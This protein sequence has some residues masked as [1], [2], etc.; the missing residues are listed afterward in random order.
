MGY[1]RLQ[2][3]RNL[4]ETQTKKSGRKE[5]KKKKGV[6]AG[7]F[8]VDKQKQQQLPDYPE[9]S[10]CL[11]FN[12]DPWSGDDDGDADP[13]TGMLTGIASFL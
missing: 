13:N 2:A 8:V 11:E 6:E 5:Q 10:G 12:H 9:D 4:R 1:T 7:F 3:Y